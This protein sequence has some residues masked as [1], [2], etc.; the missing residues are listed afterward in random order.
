[1]AWLDDHPPVRD[2]WWEGR[3]GRVTGCTVLHTAESIMDSVGPDTGAEAVA[4]FIRTRSTPGS[5]HDL[6]DSDSALQLVDY[7]H[8]AYQDGTGSNPWA[9]SISWAC[10]TSDWRAMTPQKRAAFLAQGARAFVRQ[11]AW[12]KMR[13]Y[14]LTELRR[15]TKAQ[16]DA[17]WSGFIAHGDRDPGRRT[18]PGTV[19]PN[20]FPWDEWLAACRAAMGTPVITPPT[21]GEEAMLLIR[22]SAGTVVLLSDSFALH[23]PDAASHAG[24][25]KALPQV[26]L[27]NAFFANVIRYAERSGRIESNLQG[28]LR[29]L[30]DEESAPA[31]PAP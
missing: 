11:Q 10:R 22:N 26:Q 27:S 5:Y 8:G 16:S 2:Q 13:G 15:I 9:L 21:E 19:A 24:L 12:K 29:D 31:A 1:M 4:Q 7:R 23:V 18:D 6:C 17:G 3:P 30:A 28:I 25:Q 14:P 20:L